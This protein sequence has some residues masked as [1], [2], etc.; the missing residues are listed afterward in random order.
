MCTFV[1]MYTS[2]Y[3]CVYECM[4]IYGYTH[5]RHRSFSSVCSID[6]EGDGLSLLRQGARSMCSPR[7]SGHELDSPAKTNTDEG[8]RAVVD[9]QVRDAFA[10]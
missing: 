3:V 7:Q 5:T 8:G 9:A 6:R 10:A 2:A 1:R 4:Y